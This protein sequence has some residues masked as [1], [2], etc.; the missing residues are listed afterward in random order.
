MLHHYVFIKYRAGTSE[1]HVEEFTRRML[2]LRATIPEIAQLEIGR[3]ILHEARSWDL[4]LIMRFASLDALRSYQRHPDHVRVMEFNGPQVD[5]VG[6]VD[7]EHAAGS[8][9]R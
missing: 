9:P 2:A 8:M 7:F 4:V 6:A 1:A 3:D 5:A